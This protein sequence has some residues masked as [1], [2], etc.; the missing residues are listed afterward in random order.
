L[1]RYLSGR[2]T[3]QRN[4]WLGHAFGLAAFGLALTLRFALD[5]NLPLGFPYLTFFP[6]VILTTFLAGT[7]PGLVCALLSGLAA[8]FWFIP[9]WGSFRMTHD[10]AV[11]LAFYVFI[12]SVDIAVIDAVLRG[13]ERL[14]AE[15]AKSANLAEQHRTL[16][17]ELQHRVANNMAFVASLLML[18][19][20]KVAEDPASASAVFDDAAHR[21]QVMA[22]LHRKLHDPA[23]LERPI[24]DYLHDLCT[25]LVEASG[26]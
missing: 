19:K 22:R 16:F 1:K 23:S 6:A 26:A 11:A 17:E 2:S 13:A 14:K 20:R 24:G 5:S 12:V 18:Q 9:P 21:L 8:W 4:P 25:D 10:T 7:W 15:R 3:L